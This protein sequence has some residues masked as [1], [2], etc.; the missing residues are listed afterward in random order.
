MLQGRFRGVR[1]EIYMKNQRYVKTAV[2]HV[3]EE[4]ISPQRLASYLVETENNRVKA[5]EL[6]QWNNQI[7][8]AIW[9]I[10]SLLEVG[11]RNTL[12]RHMLLRQSKLGRSEH[13]LFDDHFELG[14]NSQAAES[15]KQ[16]YKDVAR[17]IS[18]VQK[19][20]KPL[21]PS[22]IISET[23]FGFWNQLVGS[24]N[25]F[26]WPDLASAF[27]FAPTRDQKYVS[28]L[29]SDCRGIRNRISHHH[30]LH[31]SSIQR[32]ELMILELAKALH[33][34]FADWVSSQSRVSEVQSLFPLEKV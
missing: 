24:R 29:F 28:T 14:R 25:K 4:M 11:L 6:Y 16:P 17:A 21:T 3:V 12:D 34:D 8:V 31:Q 9:E 30:K 13:W 5:I 19:N 18:Q 27:P 2:V 23:P 26:L 7:S 20:G 33:P 15:H 10:L 1:E 32:G 22:Q